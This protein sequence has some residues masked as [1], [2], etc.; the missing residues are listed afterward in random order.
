M[1]QLLAEID[2]LQER[3]NQ[4]RPLPKETLQS[5]R[6]DLIVKWTYNSNAIEGNTLTLIE[7]KV[8]LEDGLTIGGKTVREHLEALNH[9]EAIH[10]L[11]KSIKNETGLTQ[12]VIKQIH[13]LILSKIDDDYAGEYRDKQV[14][15]VGAKHL[16]SEPALISEQ[17]E[18]LLNWYNDRAQSLHPLERASILHSDFVKIHPFIDGNG[19]TARLL[20]NLELMKS[21]YVPVVIENDQRMDYYKALD[22]AHM[23]DDCSDFI[24]LVGNT[25]KKMLNFYLD[26]LK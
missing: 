21:G 24:N 16:P 7:T 3:F 9:R 11:E 23:T 6:E 12:N 1:E 20:L 8:V 15:V 13:S 17:M 22:H 14:F 4:K 2:K 25:L 26:F 19:R 10:F 18:E 5:M